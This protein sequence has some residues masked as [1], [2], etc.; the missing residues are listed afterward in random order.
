[1]ANLKKVKKDLVKL[2]EEELKEVLE[3]LI[4]DDETK[5]EEEVAEEEKPEEKQE[6]KV[7]VKKEEPKKEETLGLT[8]K[9]LEEL[10]SKFSE[11]FVKKEELEEV[12]KK[13]KP[14]GADK[15]VEK[16]E[17]KEE[18]RLEDYLS[19]VNSQFV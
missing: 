13:A 11:N 9:D 10:L 18:I 15:K 2:N 19:K 8:K 12:K 5:V 14:F 6:V 16:V 1:M 17:V 4:D 3:F 7:E